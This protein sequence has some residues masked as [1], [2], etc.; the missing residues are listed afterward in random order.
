MLENI[1]AVIFDLDGTLV[2]SMWMW[3]A[4]DIEFLSNYDIDFPED[5]GKQVEGMSFTET[6]QYF[7]DTFQLSLTLDDI[8]D[9]WNRMAYDK[10]ATE[11]PFKEGAFEFL[12]YL[13][14][15]DI[16]IGIATSNS[17]QLVDAVIQSLGMGKYLN[18]VRT[19]CEVEKGKPSP[20]I[21]LLVADD[22][23]VDPA[24]CLVFE[25]VPAGLMAGN[26][27]GMITC[28]VKDDFSKDLI[29]AKKEL[30]DYYIETYDDI[31]TKNYEVL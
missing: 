11:V 22:L 16:K 24:H 18:S 1:E 31:L 27:A 10:Y 26:A 20:D 23:G 6:A 19:A 21:Y 4:I 3:E 13:K 28:A 9:I 25:D 2:D 5:L 8:K 17:R 30:A 29:V 14:E 12:R 15:N 7:K